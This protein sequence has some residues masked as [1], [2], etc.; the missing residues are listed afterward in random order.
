MEIQDKLKAFATK[1][2]TNPRDNF[3]MTNGNSMYYM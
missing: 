1:V 2:T 3:N